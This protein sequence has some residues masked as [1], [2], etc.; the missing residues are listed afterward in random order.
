MHPELQYHLAGMMNT[1]AIILYA[2]SKEYRHFIDIIY[3]HIIPL[4]S[5]RQIVQFG[6]DV[7]GSNTLDHKQFVKIIEALKVHNLTLVEVVGLF[8]SM[9]SNSDVQ[10]AMVII[11]SFY[12]MAD[13]GT[14]WETLKKLLIKFADAELPI[15]VVT[16]V[17]K[18]CVNI[19]RNKT[20]VDDV[21]DSFVAKLTS[22]TRLALGG[23]LLKT[24]YD[25]RYSH[26]VTE[27]ENPPD[28]AAKKSNWTCS[29]A[30]PDSSRESVDFPLAALLAD[31]PST[32]SALAGQPQATRETSKPPSASQSDDASTSGSGSYTLK[33]LG[34]LI[35]YTLSRRFF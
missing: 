34:T 28:E 8:D 18:E 24:F 14:Y 16:A 4:M 10:Y 30:S 23:D 31:R 25:L 3:E 20:H 13:L 26:V 5:L 6:I 17:L 19:H 11:E 29:I 7:R 1:R 12:N 32:S 2:I 22:E 15:H 9:L 27:T 35:S 21:H 33:Q